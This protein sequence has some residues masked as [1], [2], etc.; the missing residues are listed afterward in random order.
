MSYKE[1]F[2]MAPALDLEIEL[3]N[4]T[5]ATLY[6]KVNEVIYMEQ[7]TSLDDGTSRDVQAQLSLLWP[8]A[9]A[10]KSGTKPLRDSSKSKA[11]A[12]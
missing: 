5:T 6:G 4:V 3:M 2:A 9:S 10:S 11:C 12:A 1:L 8:E 7:P